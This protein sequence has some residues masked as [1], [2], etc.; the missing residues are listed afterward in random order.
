[1]KSD[2]NSFK[3]S[4]QLL[5]KVYTFSENSYHLIDNQYVMKNLG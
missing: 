1:M 5:T 3:K 2:F 4:E